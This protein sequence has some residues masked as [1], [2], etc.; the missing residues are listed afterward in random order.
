M[1]GADGAP[2]GTRGSG[3]RARPRGRAAKAPAG[4]RTADLEPLYDVEDAEEQAMSSFVGHPY[5]EVVEVAPG[6]GHLLRRRPHPGFGHHRRRRRGPGWRRTDTDRLL[7]DLGRPETPI[8]HDPT[9]IVDG[10]DIVLVES[11]YGGRERGPRKRL[12]AC[13][14]SD[15]RHRRLSLRHRSDA[16]GRLGHGPTVGGRFDPHPALPR[17][18][19]SLARQRHLPR[20]PGYYDEET[21]RLLETGACR[22]TTGRDHHPDG[23]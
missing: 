22:S 9:A 7:G 5:G 17:L 11:T 2:G 12:S 3:G 18:A 14:P 13:W 6:V 21:H 1:G 4:G 8:I 19:G 10:A 23:R 15:Q 20:L 16:G